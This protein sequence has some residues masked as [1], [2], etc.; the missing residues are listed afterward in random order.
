MEQVKDDRLE[1]EEVGIA[2]EAV[3]P[4]DPHEEGVL[5]WVDEPKDDDHLPLNVFQEKSV[6]HAQREQLQVH[7][8]QRWVVWEDY[9]EL[10]DVK[11]DGLHRG[12]SG[13]STEEFS[14]I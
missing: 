5:E 14:S 1:V 4:G 3:D 8:Q 12:R 7:V 11:R 6:V 2:R 9:A 13:R 10:K